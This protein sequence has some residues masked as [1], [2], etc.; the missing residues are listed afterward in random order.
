[1]FR[2]PYKEK[3][4]YSLGNT[5]IPSWILKSES[6]KKLYH[7]ELHVFYE[8]VNWNKFI[9]QNYQSE[10]VFISGVYVL[11]GTLLIAHNHIVNDVRW[12]CD[13]SWLVSAC[14][15][16]TVRLWQR[17]QTE[18]VLTIATKL[19]NLAEGDGPK[20]DKVK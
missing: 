13:S 7:L 16:K 9:L 3:G 4:S 1:M 10:L 20:K 12:S 8:A 19:H 15:D 14:D 18:A 11:P 5:C 2:I 17:G 6:P